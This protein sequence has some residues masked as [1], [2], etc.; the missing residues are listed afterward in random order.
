M[1]EKTRTP[2]SSIK[3]KKNTTIKLK[4]LTAMVSE[5]VGHKLTS[6]DA[7]DIAVTQLLDRI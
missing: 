4:K 1:I 3:V 2:F 6:Y 7:L 5:Q